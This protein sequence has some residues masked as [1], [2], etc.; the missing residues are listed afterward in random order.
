MQELLDFISKECQIKL[1]EN[2][3][4]A[5]RE[6]L[7]GIEDAC[8]YAEELNET[9]KAITMGL[10]HVLYILALLTVNLG[11]MNLLPLP[12]LDGGRLI[13]LAIEGIRRKPFPA[14]YEGWIHGAG[15]AALLLLSVFIMGNDIWRLIRGG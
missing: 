2:L 6:Q 8:K 11:I 15:L 9:G 4:W 13:F 1:G 7:L 10:E 5:R 3:H 14:K 12:A